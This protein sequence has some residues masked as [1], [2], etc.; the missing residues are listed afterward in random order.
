MSCMQVP[1]AAGQILSLQQTR[2]KQREARREI[3]GDGQVRRPWCAATRLFEHREQER[4]NKEA[5]DA[6]AASQNALL[7]GPV[8]KLQYCHDFPPLPE[9]SP[10]CSNCMD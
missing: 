1:K 8:H 4:L 9:A 10:D 5:E 3:C 2:Y 6:R 7:N